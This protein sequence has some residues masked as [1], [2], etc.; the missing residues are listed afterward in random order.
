[1]RGDFAEA[2]RILD[3]HFGES[4]Y[5]LRSMFREDQRKILNLILKSALQEA[6]T[7]YRQIFDT[8]SPM[9]RYLTDLNV[10]LPHAFEMVAQFAVNSSLRT[11][12]ENVEDLDLLRIET[13]LDAARRSNVS[14]DGATL[15]FALRKTIKKLSEQFL[16]NPSDMGLMQKLEGAAALARR[17][18]FEVNIWRAQ[19][20]YYRLLQTVFPE[21]AQKAES[22]DAEA[23]EWVR[24]FVSLGN[25]LAVRVEVP[26][27]PPELT[28]VAS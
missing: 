25:N 23:Q 13:L 26:R 19:N 3:R 14:L 11:A 4:T 21:V 12:F 20:N 15:G 9:M 2:I 6:E 18:P 28:S 27:T 17:L 24:Y 22:G 7:A 16:E 8:H 5:S 10:P 1:M